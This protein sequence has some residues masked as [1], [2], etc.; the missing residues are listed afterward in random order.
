MYKHQSI[1][2]LLY[3]LASTFIAFPIL[4]KD[5][6]VNCVSKENQRLVDTQRPL[7]PN[8]Y[9]VDIVNKCGECAHIS[10]NT[11]KNGNYTDFARTFNN[12]AAGE[13]RTDRMIVDGV[14]TWE[15]VVVKVISCK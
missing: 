4:A 9:Y 13:T 6:P 8:S 15:L 12:V 7:P 2:L 10:T 11:K 3:S 1:Q 5:L 14:G